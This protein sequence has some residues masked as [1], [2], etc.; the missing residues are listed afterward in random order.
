MGGGSTVPTACEMRERKEQRGKVVKRDKGSS[1]LPNKAGQPISV[2]ILTEMGDF[3]ISASRL[4]A[5]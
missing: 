2:L 1:L 3:E 5:R 4:S